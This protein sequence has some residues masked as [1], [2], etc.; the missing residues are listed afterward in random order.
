MINFYYRPTPHSAASSTIP[1]STVSYANIRKTSLCSSSSLLPTSA[2]SVNG[3]A[4]ASPTT[5]VKSV[6][7]G[8]HDSVGE[9]KEQ[10]EICS[11]R[12]LKEESDSMIVLVSSSTNS[13]GASSE[14]KPLKS[15]TVCPYCHKDFP[16]DILIHHKVLHFRERF[17]TCIDCG[18]N[19]KTEIGLQ[20]HRCEV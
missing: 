4:T 7:A 20:K 12:T 5:V 10:N 16:P 2:V 11:I 9:V 6:S 15:E 19:F 13:P 1:K 14:N 18:K 3:T 17:F 8:A